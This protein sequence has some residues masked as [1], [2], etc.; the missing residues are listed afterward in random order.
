MEVFIDNI[1]GWFEQV[2]KTFAGAERVLATPMF[3]IA[4]HSFSFLSIL[5]YGGIS[6]Y[7][8]IAVVKWVT[9]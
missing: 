6:V 1:L 7:L 5:T 3:E 9:V 2:V 8:I 4:N